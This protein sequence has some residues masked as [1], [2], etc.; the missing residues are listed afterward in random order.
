M[1]LEGLNPKRCKRNFFSKFRIRETKHLSTDADSSTN[2]K[3]ILLVR[4]NLR[5]FNTLYKQ[6]FSNLRQFF[7]LLFPK[8]SENLKS[9]D[10]GPWEVGTKRRLTRAK[11]L[12]K[13]RNFVFAAAILH[14]L[15]AKVFKAE[16]TSF[17]YFSQG[18]RKSKKF[19]HW[20]LGAKRR[21]EKNLYQI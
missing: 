6:K 21:S 7:P 16:T 13:I 19:G 18:F 12:K 10:I 3:K 14:P 9:L 5:R 1:K 4:Q 15:W 20:T 8:D 11:K 2:T 17:H